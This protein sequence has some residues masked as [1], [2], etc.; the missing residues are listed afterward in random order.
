MTSSLGL[1]AGATISSQMATW[2]EENELFVPEEE[3]GEEAEWEEFGVENVL[4]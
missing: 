3:D 4:R 1:Y 2:L